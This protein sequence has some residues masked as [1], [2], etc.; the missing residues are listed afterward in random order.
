M[1]DRQPRH[2]GRGLRT[3]RPYPSG[4][5]AFLRSWGFQFHGMSFLD[6]IDFVIW[7][8]LQHPGEP[9]FRINAVHP[10][11]LDE[12]ASDNGGFTATDGA[13]EEIVLATRGDGADR[14]FTDV[15]VEFEPPVAETGPLYRPRVIETLLK[16]TQW[17]GFCP[18]RRVRTGLVVNAQRAGS[19]NARCNRP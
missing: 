1:A 17:P 8:A 15:V 10:G 9:G 18:C 4:Q 3:D 7:Q 11:G 2:A 19:A 5:A 14:A 13:H 16:L 6:A 12:G